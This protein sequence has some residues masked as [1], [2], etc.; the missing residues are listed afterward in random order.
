MSLENA[1]KILQEKFGDDWER[2][3]RDHKRLYRDLKSDPDLREYIGD[4]SFEWFIIRSYH[5]L[6]KLDF[7]GG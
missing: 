6:K 5:T 3:E 2:F 1:V 7:T 4:K